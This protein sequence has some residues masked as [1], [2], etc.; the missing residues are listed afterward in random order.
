MIIEWWDCPLCYFSQV[1]VSGSVPRRVWLDCPEDSVILGLSATNS[2][3]EGPKGDVAV[4]PCQRSDP[5]WWW[6][7]TQG[8]WRSEL[9]SEAAA[10]W[11]ERDELMDRRVPWHT[12]GL[13]RGSLV[14]WSDQLIKKA[15][16]KKCWEVLGRLTQQAAL[17]V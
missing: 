6:S 14:C 16:G 15:V 5:G 17:A 12:H 10:V 4:V 1:S 9:L 3:G 11:R 7:Q 2:A 8:E 13:Y